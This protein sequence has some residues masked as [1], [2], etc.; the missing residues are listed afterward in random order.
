M[1]ATPETFDGEEAVLVDP[2]NIM[3]AE[4]RQ[5]ERLS[6]YL[7]VKWEGLLGRYEGMLSDISAGGCFILSDEKVVVR[8]LLRLEI[9]LHTGEWVK[10]WGEV[11]NSFPPVGFGVMYTE[12][13]DED[14][15]QR[16]HITLGQTKLIQAAVAA[17]KRLDE[18]SVKRKH[19]D[20][21]VTVIGLREYK[22]KLLLALPHVN[23]ALL[24][25]PDCQKKT[26]LHRS[27]QAYADA[28]RV[29]AA[30]TDGGADAK[31]V[32][33]GYKNLKETYEAPPDV[34][35]ALLKG[36]FPAVLQFLWQKGYICL[37][38]AS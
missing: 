31:A 24:G 3:P 37:T 4:R 20:S 30:M 26:A 16:L 10:V 1:S 19:G 12:V 5:H 7:H 22:T 17:L 8:E 15:E 13:D 2:G 34:L 36:D 38:F 18:S 29:W 14:G 33:A 32:A 35:E 9:Q 6:V 23:R 11:S 28:G 25:L 27:V 21:G